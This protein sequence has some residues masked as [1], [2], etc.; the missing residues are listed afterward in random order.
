MPRSNDN[1]QHDVRLKDMHELLGYEVRDLLSAEKQ[2]V[3][4]LPKM[5]RAASNGQLAKAFED[6]LE[7]TKGHVDR[8]ETVCE[9]LGI[10]APGETCEA[11]QGLI[12]EGEEI[13]QARGDDAVRDAALIAAAQR[14]EHYEMAGYGAARSFA[15][16]LGRNDVADL[17]QQTLDEEGAADSRLTE[18]AIDWVNDRAVQEAH[19]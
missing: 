1:E 13:I 18:L 3:D 19:G 5:A 17:L 14:V 4:A 16:H 2:L 12:D 8:L 7:E 10:D 9:K 11:M 15:R 6:H